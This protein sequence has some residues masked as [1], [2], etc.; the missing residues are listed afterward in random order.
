MTLICTV[1]LCRFQNFHAARGLP[2]CPAYVE[3]IKLIWVD[4]TI[5]TSLFQ[6]LWILHER[7]ITQSPTA[8]VHSDTPLG[9]Y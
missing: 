9:L 7:L 5:H 2:Q 3:G 1:K 8:P 6:A 4:A